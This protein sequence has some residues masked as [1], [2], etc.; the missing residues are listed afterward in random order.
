M[1]RWSRAA[2]CSN[3]FPIIMVGFWR[4]ETLAAGMPMPE[5]AVGENDATVLGEDN[6]RRSRQIFAVHSEAV[7]HVNPK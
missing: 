1:L 7:T 5:A 6:V 4:S 3:F 2:F